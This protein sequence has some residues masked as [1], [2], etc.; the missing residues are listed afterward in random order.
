MRACPRLRS[1]HL[2][3]RVIWM[4][5]DG[6]L[7]W[8]QRG[9]TKLA[10]NFLGAVELEQPD[11]AEPWGDVHSDPGP[12]KIFRNRSGLNGHGSLKA[13]R[14]EMGTFFRGA[15]R[16]AQTTRMSISSPRRATAGVRMS[17]DRDL[18]PLSGLNAVR[19]F[20]TRAPG[21]VTAAHGL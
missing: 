18:G 4:L 17:I 8:R 13:D 20:E 3:C 14:G 9:R 7:L 5:L 16:E 15:G 1:T 6:V 19:T 12:R 11:V 21:A 10:D 2:S